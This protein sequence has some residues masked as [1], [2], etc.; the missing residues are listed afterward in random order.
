M[1]RRESGGT[2]SVPVGEVVG[3]TV[4]AQNLRPEAVSVSVNSSQWIRHPSQRHS[5]PR[6]CDSSELPDSPIRTEAIKVRRSSKTI[7]SDLA[8]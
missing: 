3:T 1:W 2:A 5:H 6:R 8:E 7:C 4:V